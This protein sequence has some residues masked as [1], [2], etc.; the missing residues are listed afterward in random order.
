MELVSTAS[1]ALAGRFF[2]TEPPGKTRLCSSQSLRGTPRI[3]PPDTENLAYL[4]PTIY[5][6]YSACQIEYNRNKEMTAS[7]SEDHRSKKPLKFPAFLLTLSFSN[8][9]RWGKVSYVVWEVTWRGPCHRELSSPANSYMSDLEVKPSVER[10]PMK[11]RNPLFTINSKNE[12]L[13]SP[14][15]KSLFIYPSFPLS[16]M[17]MI[18]HVVY[19]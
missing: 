16:F 18:H 12:K 3:L 14:T 9:S 17:L 6:V 13:Y 4:P 1:P 5:Q 19:N 7:D 8:Y 10:F 15:P 2:T 11:R